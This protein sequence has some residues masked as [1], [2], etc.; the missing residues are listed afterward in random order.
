MVRNY[1]STSD[2]ISGSFLAENSHLRVDSDARPFESEPKM[3]SVQFL[4]VGSGV[5]NTD[6]VFLCR[7][8]DMRALEIST[9]T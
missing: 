5:G 7:F 2:V 4:Q 8:S 6:A 9:Y 1:L 3:R